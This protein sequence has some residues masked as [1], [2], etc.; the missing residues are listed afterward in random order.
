MHC[1]GAAVKKKRKE[2]LYVARNFLNPE[3]DELTPYQIL[4]V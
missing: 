3:A 1:L 4:F 2:S